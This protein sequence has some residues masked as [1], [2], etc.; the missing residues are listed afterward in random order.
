[1]DGVSDAFCYLVG[2][3]GNTLTKRVVLT[4]VVVISHITLELLG[5]VDSGTSSLF[6]SSLGWVTGVDG[7]NLS[8]VGLG[9]GGGGA[10]GSEGLLRVTGVGD[11]GT[12]AFTELTFGN[13]NLSGRVVGGWAVEGI[14]VSIVGPVLNL[15]VG[16]G[17]GGRLVL[18]A[19]TRNL[20]FYAV[21]VLRTLDALLGLLGLL[22]AGLLVDVDLLAV[23]GTT[24]ALFFVDAYLFLD[25]S[26]ATAG[27]FDGGREGGVGFF[28]TFPS[29]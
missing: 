1:V 18:M 22:I 20:E 27:G 9:L 17:G 2:S 12:S 4:F 14:E 21:C 16:G 25:V 8:T 10:R 6:Y 5:G 28:V 23:L 13:V 11:D 24:E 29:V 15:D 3:L 26:L 7:L 19:V